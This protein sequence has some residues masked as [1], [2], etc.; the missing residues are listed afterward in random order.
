[1][2][3]DEHSITVRIFVPEDAEELSQL[4]IQNL[5]Q[6]LIQDYAPEAIEILM[7]SFTPEKLIAD[8]A[9]QFT[10]IAT[11]G[12]DIV[13]TA[14]LA[15]DRVRSVFVDVASH[16]TGIGRQLMAALEMEARQRNLKSIYLMAGLS[17]CGFYAKLGYETVERIDREING[18]PLP[19]IRMEKELETNQG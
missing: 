11:V 4:I 6:V 18:I 16:G 7:P 3:Q 2:L 12:H 13:G 8:D 15:D 14:A 19:V 9:R 1:M 10:L 5:Q 17:A